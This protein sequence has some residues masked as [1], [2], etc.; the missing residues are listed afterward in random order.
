MTVRQ[1]LGRLGERDTPAI[2]VR[3]V[4]DKGLS[5]SLRGAAA[6]CIAPP[7]LGR[8]NQRVSM[9]REDGAQ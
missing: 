4:W 8:I 7:L 6:M 9:A 3:S 1:G 2:L 5:P